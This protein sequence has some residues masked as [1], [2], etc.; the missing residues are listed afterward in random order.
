MMSTTQTNN[1]N[2]ASQNNFP[3]LNKEGEGQVIQ[4]ATTTFVSDANLILSEINKPLR[5]DDIFLRSSAT[6]VDESI[7]AFL[8]KPVIFMQGVFNNT[9][10]VSTFSGKNI[11]RDIISSS[12]TLF[13][14]KLDG[15]YGFRATTVLTMVVNATRFQQGRYMLCFMSTAGGLNAGPS[16]PVLVHSNTLTQRTQLPR[17]EI[18]LNC[19]TQAVLKIP[20]VSTFNMFPF[21]NINIAGLYDIGNVQIFPYIP[22]NSVSGSTSAYFTVYAHFEDVELIGPAVPQMA[23]LPT[24]IERNSKQAGP[25]SSVLTNFTSAINIWNDVPLLSSYTRSAA[26]VTDALARTADI[27]GFSKPGNLDKP[28]RVNRVPGVYSA[29]VDNLDQ[30]LPMSLSVKNEVAILP[31]FSGTDVD[32]MDFSFIATIPAYVQTIIFQTGVIPGTNILNFPVAPPAAATRTGTSGITIYDFT[33]VG[34]MINLFDLWRGSL[35][36][37]FKIVKTEFHSGRLSFSFLPQQPN[38]TAV[39]TNVSGTQYINREIIDIREANIVTLT[40][41]YMSVKPW[42]KQGEAT[43]FLQIH[44]VDELMAP[45]TV[46]SSISIIM[47]VSGG[48]DIEFAFPKATNILTPVFHATPQMAEFYQ[49]EPEMERLQISNACVLVNKTL[50][51]STLSNDKMSSASACIGERIS[52][53]RTLLK[54]T[55]WMTFT[56]GNNAAFNQLDIFPFSVQGFYDAATPVGPQLTND[57]YTLLSGMY[58]LCRGG[59]RIRLLLPRTSTNVISN[60][61]SLSYVYPAATMPNIVIGSTNSGAIFAPPL[62]PI[63]LHNTSDDKIIEL[64]VPQYLDVHSRATSTTF[65]PGSAAFTGEPLPAVRVMLKDSWPALLIGRSGSDD[66]NFGQFISIPPLTNL[67]PGTGT[68]MY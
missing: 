34:L 22:I 27:F 57:L 44:V 64:N 50:G 7:K 62:S 19:D 18:D 47:E 63:V 42:L 12:G 26:W 51:S 11:P 39:G 28:M 58:G 48:P 23:P 53:F 67:G 6:N 35:V 20:F 3:N 1:P 65:S 49:A 33:P 30:A 59:V 25:V 17:I 21:Q 15:Y 29:N 66:C 4:D 40:I 24:D 32:E 8:A 9:D 45:T 2:D 14:N 46:A 10:T 16:N 61:P 41:P 31:G 13:S 5:L 54:S 60:V 43:G 38:A 37:T 68:G 55:N 36:F 56:A 52:S